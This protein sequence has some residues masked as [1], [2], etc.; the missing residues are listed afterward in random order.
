MY[1]GASLGLDEDDLGTLDPSRSKIDPKPTVTVLLMEADRGSPIKLLQVVLR[2]GA[3]HVQRNDVWCK[4]SSVQNLRGYRELRWELEAVSSGNKTS[5][6]GS[7]VLDLTCTRVPPTRKGNS[8]RISPVASICL[9]RI[10]G[11]Q[12]MV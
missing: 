3:T 11:C 2:P 12:A 7:E 9:A 10:S 8:A 1:V 6:Y 5:S 4:N